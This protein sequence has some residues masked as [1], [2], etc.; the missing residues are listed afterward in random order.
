MEMT[1]ILRERKGKHSEAQIYFSEF[2]LN[3]LEL[4][5]ITCDIVKLLVVHVVTVGC[6]NDLRKND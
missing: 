3:S 4:K 1:M 2:F 6:I 5:K